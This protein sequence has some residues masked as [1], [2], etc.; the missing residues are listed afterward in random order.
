MSW[1][2]LLAVGGAVVEGIEHAEQIQEFGEKVLGTITPRQ[3]PSGRRS[4]KRAK[5]QRSQFGT[6]KKR[7]VSKRLFR[8]TDFVPKPRSHH[9]RNKGQ[10]RLPPSR[11]VYSGGTYVTT[12]RAPMQITYGPRTP[13]AFRARRRR[14]VPT[15]RALRSRR[16]GIRARAIGARAGR[17]RRYVRPRRYANTRYKK[18]VTRRARPYRGIRSYITGLPLS[19]TIWLKT[20]KQCRITCVAGEWGVIPF[21]MNDLLKPLRWASAGTTTQAGAYGLDEAQL[22]P[23]HRILPFEDKLG[24]AAPLSIVQPAG[25]DQLW[26]RYDKYRVLQSTVTIQMTPADPQAGSRIMAGFTTGLYLNSGAGSGGGVVPAGTDQPTFGQ[27]YVNV[28]RPDVILIDQYKMI[29]KKDKGLVTIGGLAAGGLGSANT[30][31]K[32]YFHNQAVAIV[33]RHHG[34]HNIET[35]FFEGTKTVA[36]AYVPMVYFLAADLGAANATLLYATVT[37]MHKVRLHI[38]NQII[39]PESEF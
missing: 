6:T 36:P 1:K 23:Q 14:W 2:A 12:N 22:A 15:A 34:A 39:P 38:D 24:S 31:K 16:A 21:P 13:M 26:G 35:N 17:K 20:Q 4:Q 11:Q 3:N 27:K 25:Y 8:P 19:Q 10:P 29:P 28:H 37:I 32:T 33:K 18:R 9:R 5:F 7:K 30:F